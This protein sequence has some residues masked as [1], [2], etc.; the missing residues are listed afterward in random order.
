MTSIQRRPFLVVVAVSMALVSSHLD[1]RGS[2][3]AFGREQAAANVL[4][5][6]EGE[7]QGGSLG[8]ALMASADLDGD[9]SAELVVGEP[10]AGHGAA[11]AG[12]VT[13]V[14]G[15]K[16]QSASSFDMRPSQMPPHQLRLDGLAGEHVG[17]SLAAV[18]DWD[19]DGTPELAI[20]AP[21][22]AGAG[23]AGSGRVYLLK[24]GPRLRDLLSQSALWAL[25]DL[26]REGV[27]A[28]FDGD[29]LGEE[30]G[31]ALASGGDINGDGRQDLLVGAPGLVGRDANAGSAYVLLGGSGWLDGTW[32]NRVV[33]G[34]A[35]SPGFRLRGRHPGEGFGE[36]VAILRDISGDERDEIVVSAPK[37]PEPFA[38]AGRVEIWAMVPELGADL[39]A[40]RASPNRRAEITDSRDEWELV[41]LADPTGVSEGA[42][43]G[44][45]LAS[46][47]G[48]SAKSGRLLVGVPGDGT[49]VT[50]GAGVL[51][52]ID[53]HS[54]GLEDQLREGLQPVKL[55]A[56][57]HR[58]QSVGETIALLPDLDGDELPEIAYSMRGW[59]ADTEVRGG[60]V[61]VGLL[62]SGGAGSG[63]PANAFV[64]VGTGDDNLPLDSRVTLAGAADFLGTGAKM[65]LVG[66]PDADVGPSDGAGKARPGR[67][68]PRPLQ[69]ARVACLRKWKQLF[70]RPG[71]RKS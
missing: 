50:P 27:V 3:G 17:S 62:F 15:Q 5:R 35:G 4:L 7:L 49:P 59:S 45:A 13:I 57:E 37:A 47:P 69:R 12:A 43:F 46:L 61:R 2:Q 36:G 68:P 55:A 24:G 23:G 20:G 58:G 25:A 38:D 11:G 52:S 66:L 6:L 65:L 19:G 53:G 56:G 42:G 22:A 51:F 1:P 64:D 31:F 29:A 41:L 67:R 18:G 21:G 14:F 26:V 30:T 28:V 8:A 48:A 63:V 54:P 40:D 70:E 60:S 10:E 44:T 9:G 33:E 32:Q 71:G 39:K 16:G 34:D